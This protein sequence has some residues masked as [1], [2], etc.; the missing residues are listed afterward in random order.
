MLIDRLERQLCKEV[1]KP[2]VCLS[3]VWGAKETVHESASGVLPETLPLTVSDAI[4]V[5][6]S[7]GFRFLWCD[8][9]CIP[10]DDAEAKHDAIHSMDGICKSG[11]SKS[12]R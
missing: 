6:L 9:Y 8:R 5:T 3:Y 4:T 11:P 1:D 7:V 2:Y 12:S 10:Q